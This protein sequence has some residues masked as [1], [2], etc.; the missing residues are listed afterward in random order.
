MRRTGMHATLM[1]MPDIAIACV[2]RPM[3]YLRPSW[4]HLKAPSLH[5]IFQS[6]GKGTVIYFYKMHAT[7]GFPRR[8]RIGNWLAKRAQMVKRVPVQCSFK[9]SSFAIFPLSVSRPSLKH[10]LP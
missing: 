2:R 3:L 9:L 5:H 7:A 6:L 1:K 8:V 10:H 4:W